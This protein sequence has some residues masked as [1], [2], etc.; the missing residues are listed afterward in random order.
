MF[1]KDNSQNSD[2]NN[3]INFINN[4]NEKNNIIS[5]NNNNHTIKI[6]TFVRETLIC[7][8]TELHRRC[9]QIYEA[10]LSFTITIHSADHS[11]HTQV[12]SVFSLWTSLP[13][14]HRRC[15][16][17]MSVNMCMVMHSIQYSASNV[18]NDSPLVITGNARGSSE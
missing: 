7:M 16:E 10:S 6:T 1:L 12:P 3:T 4:N 8:V 13:R 2:N 14:V 11:L 9:F 15:R 17:R 18:K 5:T